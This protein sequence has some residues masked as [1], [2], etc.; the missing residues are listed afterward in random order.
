MS[1][2]S[3][4]NPLDK[5]LWFKLWNLSRLKLNPA[6]SE[7]SSRRR[8][9]RPEG[10]FPAARIAIPPSTLDHR[11]KALKIDK[12]KV[13]IPLKPAQSARN[14][15]FPK[16]TRFPKDASISAACDEAARVFP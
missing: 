10:E 4:K 2:S 15:I 11:I 16:I 14:T 1:R 8:W 6:A 5:H 9:P 13:Q 7:R 12:T 3:P